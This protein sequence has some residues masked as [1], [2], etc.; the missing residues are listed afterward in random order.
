[1]GMEASR[2]FAPAPPGFIALMPTRLRSLLGKVLPTESAA[3]MQKHPPRSVQ[4]SE[5]ALRLP[6]GIG[7]YPPL[8][9]ALIV[10]LVLWWGYRE[11]FW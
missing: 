8:S 9:S 7:P 1:M 4:A 5:S 2:G 10:L 6:P 11:D 3:G